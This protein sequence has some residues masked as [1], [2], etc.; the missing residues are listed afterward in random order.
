MAEDIGLTVPYELLPQI[1]PPSQ[2]KLNIL[3][4]LAAIEKEIEAHGVSSEPASRAFSDD[5]ALSDAQIDKLR[6]KPLQ[7]V[8]GE[9]ADAKVLLPLKDFIRLIGGDEDLR[10]VKDRLPG[11]FGRMAEESDASDDLA[12]D[13]TYDASGFP[14]PVEL[15]N[16][17]TRLIPSLSLDP[18][19]VARRVIRITMVGTPKKAEAIATE[20]NL[21]AEALAREYVKY[22]VAFVE[23]TKNLEIPDFSL[24]TV[25]G[26]LV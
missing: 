24:L 19:H 6:S 21:R 15:R 13:T 26:G 18:D 25:L 7:D 1:G 17:I 10:T 20:T 5:E 23:A 4:K 2:S 11:I 16:F 3:Q 9:L 8:C 22:K 12:K 14:L